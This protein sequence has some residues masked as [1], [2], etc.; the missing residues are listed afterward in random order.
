MVPPLPLPRR[1]RQVGDLAVSPSQGLLAYTV[2][3][4]GSE[5]FDL[6]VKRL[7]SSAP[8]TKGGGGEE[9]EQGAA[10]KAK[11]AEATEEEVDRVCGVDGGV[12]WGLDD[13]SLY[14]LKMDDAHRPYQ[15]WR[16]TVRKGKRHEKKETSC[17]Y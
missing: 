7:Q 14:Y 3:T 8:A 1:R 5:T 17:S 6:V 11:A 10:G 15:A 12:A 16:H 9:E 4:D 13:A 2:D